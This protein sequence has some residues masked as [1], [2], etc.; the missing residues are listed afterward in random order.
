MLIPQPSDDP[1]DP[2]NWT[3]GKKH[4]ILFIVTLSGFLCEF[5]AG[6]ANPA[7]FLQG[8][9]WGMTAHH[10]LYANNLFVAMM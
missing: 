4:T 9:E 1:E 8:E 2:L 10:V 6:V 7:I 5:S 3:W